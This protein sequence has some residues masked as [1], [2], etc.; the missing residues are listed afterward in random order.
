MRSGQCRYKDII[1]VRVISWQPSLSTAT[2]ELTVNRWVNDHVLMAQI[3]QY[4]M[5]TY[6]G[7][8][9]DVF[10]TDWHLELASE[11]TDTVGIEV[12]I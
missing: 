9:A 1:N 11:N 2:L 12:E 3:G 6:G 10:Q 5:E 8:V 4:V 7:R